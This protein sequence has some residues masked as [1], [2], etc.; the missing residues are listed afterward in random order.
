M[1]PN[2]GMIQEA[3]FNAD[4]LGALL[5]GGASEPRVIEIKRD[6]LG[7]PDRLLEALAADETTTIR[8]WWRHGESAD[9]IEWEEA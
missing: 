1:E 2:K 8:G 3:G 7:Y 9:D 6:G 5:N 4:E